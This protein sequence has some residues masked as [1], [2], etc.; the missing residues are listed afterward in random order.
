VLREAL[1]IR[2]L[3]ARHHQ[4]GLTPLLVRR[5]LGGELGLLFV[6]PADPAS[7]HQVGRW[8]VLPLD[9][10]SGE[11]GAPIDLGSADLDGAVPRPCAEHDDGW[12]LATSLAT[13]PAIDFEGAHGY[14]DDVELRLRLDPADRCADGLAAA[15]G[16]NFGEQPSEAKA[17]VTGGLPLIVRERYTGQRWQLRCEGR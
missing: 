4:L 12:L 13:N 9:P 5:A 7:G 6:E 11:L 2:R 16:R 10:S 15:A 1:A 3:D 8:H 14:V 17:T